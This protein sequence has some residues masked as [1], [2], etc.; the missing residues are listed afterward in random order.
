MRARWDIFCRVIDNFGDIGVCW[1][2]ARQ[3][4]NEHDMQVRLW[5]D[6]WSAF[7]R[8]NPAAGADHHFQDGVLV[9]QWPAIWTDVG[10]AD[11]ASQSAGAADVV[12]EAFGCELP[13]EYLAA[14]STREQPSLWLNL[15]YLS[16][17]VWVDDYHGLPSLHSSG[18]AKY[19]FFPGFTRRTGGLLR[20][21]D[22]IER[23]DAFQ[24]S[25]SLQQ[26]F[27]ARI[28][29]TRIRSARLIS[30]F[31]YESENLGGW[32]DAMSVGGEVSQLLVPEG[33]IVEDVEGWVGEGR[34]PAGKVY[35]RGNLSLQLIPF[36]SQDE[37]DLLLWASDFNA[38]RGEDSFV[39]A[40]WAGRP[41]LWQPYPQPEGVHL[42]KL[43]AFLNLYCAGLS[44]AAAQSLRGLW[45]AWS[46]GE[47]MAEH[48]HL[49]E[50]MTPELTTH[51]ENWCV[52]L[53]RQINIVDALV[54]FYR[55]WI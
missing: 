34:L 6:D 55:N 15:E 4:A 42:E 24:A 38:V 10:W 31:A 35:T 23:R 51:A 19:F 7:S 9:R 18:L 29:V 43:D 27:F 39:R 3:L 12:I 13:E 5:V 50:K 37:Y 40:Q 8:L 52:S 14:M 2:L 48:W 49:V 53:S 45:R 26:A 46:Q 21:S 32:L 33:R 54:I 20:E 16:A 28:G 22:L 44:P 36:V 47:P 30:L 25:E 1:R 11:I 41:F 17:E